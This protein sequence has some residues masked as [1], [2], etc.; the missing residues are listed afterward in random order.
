[1]TSVGYENVIGSSTEELVLAI[2][3]MFI[4]CIIFGNMTGGIKNVL[5]KFYFNDRYFK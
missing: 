1:M 4:S 2:L 5:E 3:A